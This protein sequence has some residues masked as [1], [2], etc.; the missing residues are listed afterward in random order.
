M[1]AIDETGN[2]YGRL[3]VIERAQQKT[4]HGKIRWICRC[5]CGTVKPV[6]AA[7]LRGGATVSCGC[8]ASEL[9]SKK[10]IARHYNYLRHRKINTLDRDDEDIL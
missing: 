10:I 3:V 9:S 2:R 6:L 4:K 5:D 7:S 1:S 8:F